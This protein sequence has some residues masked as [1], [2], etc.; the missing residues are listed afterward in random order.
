MKKS[1]SVSVIFFSASIFLADYIPV[2]VESYI[3]L[4]S[5]YVMITLMIYVATL[6][7]LEDIFEGYFKNASSYDKPSISLSMDIFSLIITAVDALT[8]RSIAS[9][10]ADIMGT[11]TNDSFVSMTLL[12]ALIFSTFQLL[13]SK[14]SYILK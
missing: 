10:I 2:D 4:S 3:Q 7:Y 11:Y 1:R 9:F 5:F 13:T 8:G 14:H 6:G 12:I